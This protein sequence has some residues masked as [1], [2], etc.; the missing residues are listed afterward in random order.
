M[1]ESEPR[2]DTVLMWVVDLK[3]V[4]ALSMAMIALFSARDWHDTV[5][6]PLGHYLGFESNLVSVECCQHV[7]ALARSPL[8][9]TQTRRESPIPPIPL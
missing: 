2:L 9:R 4:V 7:S 3:G 1:S 8:R 5:S 6:T